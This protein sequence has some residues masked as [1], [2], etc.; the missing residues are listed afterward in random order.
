MHRCRAQRRSERGQASGFRLL[1]RVRQHGATRYNTRYPGVAKVDRNLQRVPP[2]AGTKVPVA[3]EN[4]PNLPPVSCEFGAPMSRLLYGVLLLLG[5]SACAAPRA[6]G[7]PLAPLGR[8]WAVPTLGLY[9]EWWDKTVACSGQSGNMKNVSFYAVDAPAGAIEL[10]GEMAHAWWVR[11]GNRI[12]LPANALG[13][14][15]LVRH[16]MLH[17]L[18]QKG[19]HPAEIFVKACHVASAAVWRGLTLS[20]G[21]REPPRERRGHLL[22]CP[23]L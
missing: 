16:E 23:L 21:P 3:A 14:E 19:S 17:A 7:A 12:Y 11:E 1:V 15:W 6:A 18:L 2:G 9:Q 8:S 20:G 5:S 22:F 10:A 13:H 4:A